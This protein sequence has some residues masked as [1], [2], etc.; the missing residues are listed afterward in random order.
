[1]KATFDEIIDALGDEYWEM[2][3]NRA[4][5]ASKHDTAAWRGGGSKQDAPKEESR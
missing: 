4:V 1:V 2:M 5:P 3:L